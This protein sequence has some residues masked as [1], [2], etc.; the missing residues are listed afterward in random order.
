MSND[1]TYSR[2]TR[3]KFVGAAAS[4]VAPCLVPAAALGRNAFTAPSERVTLGVLGTGGRGTAN[5]RSL[6]PL[7]ET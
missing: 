1:K 6:L 2:M 5:M 4:L 7:K 3:R